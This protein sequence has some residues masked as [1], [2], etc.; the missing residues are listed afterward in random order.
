MDLLGKGFALSCAILWAFAV[1]YYKRA[2]ESIRPMALTLY[3][4]AITALLLLPL[5]LISARGVVPAG[6]NSRDFLAIVLSGILGMV[7]SDTLFFVC[8]NLTGAGITAI[9]DCLYSPSV[10]IASWLFL[11]EQPKSIQLLGAGL[12]ISAILFGTWKRENRRT[13]ALS[14]TLGVLAGVL[15]MA[16]MGLAVVVMRPVLSRAPLF[17]ITGVRTL[18]STLVMLPFFLF[19]AKSRAQLRTLLTKAAWKFA[20][21]GSL[22]G[23][24]LAMTIWVAAFKYTSVNSAAVLNQTSTVLI[25]VLATLLLKEPFGWRKLTAACLAATGSLLI[26]LA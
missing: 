19:T 18:A 4:S 2:G 13:P 25:V 15:A 11:A 26:F 16:V 7:V 17:W 8:L 5:A 6:M 24:F 10:M 9:I 20:L 23:N 14:L 22:L 21:P 3:K 1:I 12:I